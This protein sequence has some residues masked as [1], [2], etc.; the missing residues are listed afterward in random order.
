MAGSDLLNLMVDTLMTL[1]ERNPRLFND[2]MLQRFLVHPATLDSSGFMVD[3]SADGSNTVGFH[4]ILN[5]LLLADGEGD[6]SEGR[7]IYPLYKEVD[8][9]PVCY[10]LGV[11][12]AGIARRVLA[13]KQE[14]PDGEVR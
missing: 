2:M 10:G 11:M 1:M 14:V 8:G 6:G 3:T 9:K 7:I 12:N 5:A 13:P 4:S